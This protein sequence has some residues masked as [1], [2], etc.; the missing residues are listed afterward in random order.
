[1][2]QTLWPLHLH[3]F[4]KELKSITFIRS[5]HQ[6]NFKGRHRTLTR[7]SGCVDTLHGSGAITVAFQIAL[8]RDGDEQTRHDVYIIVLSVRWATVLR[9]P[10]ANL[11]GYMDRHR[12]HVSLNSIGIRQC[13]DDTSQETMAPIKLC[14]KK[15]NKGHLS[16]CAYQAHVTHRRLLYNKRRWRRAHWTSRERSCPFLANKVKKRGKTVANAFYMA[17]GQKKDRSGGG[18]R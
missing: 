6:S 9:S 4:R 17:K 10:A 18:G 5:E 3:R 13:N 2:F 14:F 15:I 11:S 8:G 7:V 16:V 12:R 1:M